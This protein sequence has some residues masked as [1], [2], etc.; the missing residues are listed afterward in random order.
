MGA[1][2]MIMA[3]PNCEIDE[4]RRQE[5]VHLINDLSVEELHDFLNNSFFVDVSDS[6]ETKREQ[7]QICRERLIAALDSYEEAQD[8]RDCSTLWAPG[9]DYELLVTGGLS[10]GDEPTESFSSLSPFLDIS[11]LYDTLLEYAREDHK[12]V[13]V[14]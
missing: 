8:S 5:L 10:W 3:V 6:E 2:M 7:V 4:V 1:D 14:R 9:M 13:N 11:R 12:R